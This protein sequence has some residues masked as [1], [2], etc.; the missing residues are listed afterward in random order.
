[1]CPI[2]ICPHNLDTADVQEYGTIVRE[3][4]SAWFAW[5]SYGR[6]ERRRYCRERKKDPQAHAALLSGGPG[7]SESLH[8]AANENPIIKTLSW[9]LPFNEIV[10]VV[11]AGWDPEDEG[12]RTEWRNRVFGQ[13]CL[14]ERG[15][16]R[17]CRLG[18]ENAPCRSNPTRRNFEA[19][20]RFIPDR[21]V[22]SRPD[23][24]ALDDRLNRLAEIDWASSGDLALKPATAFA[25][26]AKSLFRFF[27]NAFWNEWLKRWRDWA[28]SLREKQSWVSYCTCL[29]H[30]VIADMPLD[31]E[32]IEAMVWALGRYAHDVL[33]VEPRIDIT[34]HLL[35]SARNEPALHALK[36][37]YRD[38]FFH[39]VEVCFLGHLLL[40]TPVPP[41]GERLLDV[42]R[43]LTG[44]SSRE[45]IL[46][47][48]YVAALL[49][50]VG[51][52]ID[53]LMSAQR[54]LKFSECSKPLSDLASRVK[55]AV[56]DL[57]RSFGGSGF[58]GFTDK[59]ETGSDHGVVGAE[60]LSSLL[61]NIRSEKGQVEDYQWALRAI[62]QHNYRKRTISFAREPLSFLLVLCDT[63][64]EW[65]RPHLLYSTAA[66]TML[67]RLFY[68]EEFADL[69]GPVEACSL[70]MDT[71]SPQPSMKF[72]LRYDDQ[73]NA[74]AGVFHL[75]VDSSS[76]LQRLVS[77][78]F[79]FKV[80]LSYV[81]PM[82]RTG[83]VWESQMDRLR[84]AARE[85]HMTFMASWFPRMG[86]MA[87][88]H[89]PSKDPFKDSLMLDLDELGKLHPIS[90]SME[91]FFPLLSRWSR[92]NEDRIFA[93][94]YAPQPPR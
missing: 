46:R 55:G 9:P 36:Q 53:V 48:W 8:L 84:D 1:V 12:K 7:A 43:R 50:D 92:F 77:H 15:E 2:W 18:D 94:D 51:Y 67:A 68:Q 44:Y 66:A 60:H 93:G 89:D 70:V 23:S 19:A 87:V 59:D 16:A 26:D 63:V 13:L 79:P 41:G 20:A 81:T 74:N 86:N 42:C 83:N 85:T 34:S 32:T 22:A 61:E 88:M 25:V 58:Q 28:P 37:Y 73:I 45:E 65:N 54:S 71:S 40:E 75:W 30:H 5:A 49:H 38:H 6:E 24:T 17:R 52:S 29:A 57:G 80:K 78:G 76:N 56:D 3:V 4:A 14:D 47:N 11:Q 82:F 10:E 69:R 31:K 62:A 21:F 90:A 64:Q 33:G 72:E 39:A 27:A 35:Q 91:D